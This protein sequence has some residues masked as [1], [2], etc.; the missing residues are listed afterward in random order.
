VVLEMA[1]LEVGF[2]DLGREDTMLLILMLGE[3]RVAMIRI[4]ILHSTKD[5][6]VNLISK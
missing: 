5:P 6:M 4:P 3:A 2:Q 1:V